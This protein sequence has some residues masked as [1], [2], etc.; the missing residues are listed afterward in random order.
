MKK[1]IKVIKPTQRHKKRYVLI[2]V[3]KDIS[4]YTQKDIF[5]LFFKNVSYFKG[6][7]IAN[8]LNIVV[9]DVF[10]NKKQ[11]L[12]RVNKQYIDEFIGSLFFIKDLGAIKVVSITTTFKRIEEQL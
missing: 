3:T 5:Y 10:S 12:F 4:K 8:L 2:E 7:I 11:I 6:F 9:L 1:K